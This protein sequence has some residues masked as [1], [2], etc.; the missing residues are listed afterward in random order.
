[1]LTAFANISVDRH[2]S[3]SNIARQAGYYAL[4]C[5]GPGPLL[6]G[7]PEIEMVVFDAH[8]DDIA[9]SEIA[10]QDFLRKRILDLLLDRTLQRPRTCLLYTS[11]SPR[12]ED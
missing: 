9:W 3:F 4:K 1:M 7:V 2:V 6:R 10:L 11:P 5:R 8:L 12:D